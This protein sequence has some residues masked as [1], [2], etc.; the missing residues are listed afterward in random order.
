MKLY[1]IPKMSKLIL[2][3]NRGREEAT[4]HK[5]DGAYSY[6]TFDSDG[7]VG[8]LSANCEMKKVGEHYEIVT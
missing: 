3:T 5:I 4:F 6:I 8:H 2:D 7:G 1:E